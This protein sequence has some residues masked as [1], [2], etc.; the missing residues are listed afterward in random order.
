MSGPPNMITLQ[1]MIDF[2]EE[3]KVKEEYVETHVDNWDDIEV[4][5]ALISPGFIYSLIND[6]EKFDWVEKVYIAN[7]GLLRI[8]VKGITLKKDKLFKK[9]I[10]IHP[11][12]GKFSIIRDHSGKLTTYENLIVELIIQHIKNTQNYMD[13][14]R[15]REEAEIFNLI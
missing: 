9:D 15:I 6:I 12:D 7:N 13:G 8:N 3:P 5:H 2:I 4:Q 10:A 1:T 14:N 11:N